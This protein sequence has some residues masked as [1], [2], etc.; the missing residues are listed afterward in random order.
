MLGVSRVYPTFF[1]IGLILPLR[2][3]HV[4]SVLY[5]DVGKVKMCPTSNASYFLIEL[6]YMEYIKLKKLFAYQISF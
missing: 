5:A 4:F 1:M 2:K 6:R 3:P